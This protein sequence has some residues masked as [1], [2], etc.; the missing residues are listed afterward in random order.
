MAVSKEQKED[1]KEFLDLLK[2]SKGS[3][4]VYFAV[5]KGS[6][7]SGVHID[8]KKP[9]FCV[10]TLKA[11]RITTMLASG[12]VKME[13][14]LTLY[15]L[16]ESNENATRKAFFQFFK[17]SEV[18][19]PGVT[20]SKIRV[21]GP[22]DWDSASEDEEAEGKSA[23]GKSDEPPAPGAADLKEKYEKLVPQ[24]N[25]KIAVRPEFKAP[26]ERVANI[27]QNELR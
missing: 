26:L 23:E 9:K 13:D 27:F 1:A 7:G 20:E 10:T 24:M 15:C 5:G 12:Q 21:L 14:P 3:L 17:E 25:S 2:K 18:S 11:K 22:K 6:D 4:K 8:K 19:I 16:K